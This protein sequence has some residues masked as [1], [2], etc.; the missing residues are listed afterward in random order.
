MPDW[1]ERPSIS[2][3]AQEGMEEGQG[4]E[5]MEEVE[6]TTVTST[7]PNSGDTIGDHSTDTPCGDT[8]SPSLNDDDIPMLCIP[9]RKS[10]FDSFEKLCKHLSQSD[11]IF[12][13]FKELYGSSHPRRFADAN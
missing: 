8:S 11:L 13:S 6:Q 10:A 7:S 9:P 5:D 12:D 3:S 1:E 2:R 4:S